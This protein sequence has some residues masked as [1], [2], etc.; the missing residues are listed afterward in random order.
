MSGAVIIRFPGTPTSAV[1]L[2]P[3]PRSRP[4]L[5]LLDGLL[6]DIVQTAALEQ[7]RGAPWWDDFAAR[8]SAYT[9]E[10]LGAVL[11]PCSRCGAAAWTRCEC[12]SQWRD[13]RRRA[14]WKRLS[15]LDRAIVAALAELRA[16]M[17]PII[18]VPVR[19]RAR[20]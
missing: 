14:T 20:R 4:R 17:E 7:E 15:P 19:V 3:V 1:A 13:R 16:D 6:D 18:T 5:T 9:G 11:L 8:Q 10:S 2:R 12:G